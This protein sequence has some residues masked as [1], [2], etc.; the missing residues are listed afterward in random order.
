M[1]HTGRRAAWWIRFGIVGGLILAVVTS[2][3]GASWA[4]SAEIRS[5]LDEPPAAP[6]ATGPAS[7]ELREGLAVSVAGRQRRAAIG[8][9][10][11][12]ARVAAGTWTMPRAG[13]GV[14]F[15]GGR[16]G[17]WEAVKAGTDGWFSGPVLRGGYVASTVSS[18]D[19]AVM[20]L[21]ASGHAM[22]YVEREPR[23]GD[24]YA[25]GFVQLP[26]RLRKGPNVFLFQTGQGRLKAR[27]TVPKAPAFFS[28]ADT[29]T[30]D[31]IADEPASG[32]AAVMVVN[33]SETWRDDLAIAARLAGGPE[34]RTAVPSLVPL[35]VRKVGFGFRGPAQRGEGTCALALALQRKR[36]GGDGDRWET[37]DRASVML[38][39]RRP[40]QT[41]KR[42]F[43]STIDGSV[44]YYAVVP[45]LPG[46]GGPADGRPGLVLTLHGAAVEALGQAAAY[47]PKP[48]LHIVAPTNRRPYG[49]DWEDWGRLDAIEVLELAQKVLDTDPRR[50]YLTGHSMGGHGTW[51][52][53]VTF[54]DRF[55]AIAPSAGWISMWSYAGARRAES[56]SLVDQ[57]MARAGAPSDTLALVR[58]LAPIGVYILH[59]DADDNVPVGQARRMRQVMG[60][61]HPDFAYHEQTGAGHWWG[62]ACVDWPPLFAFLERRMIPAPAE[63]R[64][65]DFVTASPGVSPRAHWVTIEAQVKSMVPSTVHLELDREHRRFRGTTEN[66]ARLAID[67]GRALAEPQAGGGPIAVELDGQ[68]L[69]GLSG[70]STPPGS[71]RWIWLVRSGGTWTAAR[72][73]A[74]LARKG[75]HR[76][77][78]FKEVFRNRFV[79]VIGTKGTPEENAWGLARARFDAET[80]W[81]RGNGSVDILTDAVFLDPGRA[82]ALRDRNVILYGHSE[83]N[84]A[85]PVL[86]GD[87]PVQVRR[88]EVR[89]GG[90]VV[91]GDDLTC[92]FVRP[93]PDSERAAVGVVAGSGLIGLRLADGLP[94]F[95]SGV[96]YPDCLLL[97]GKKSSQGISV[98]IAAGYFGADWDVESGEFAWS[99]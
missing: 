11:I 63:V 23:A 30:P 80:F 69:A 34:I 85:W 58:N 81:Y 88:G 66:V 13:D 28:V 43:R 61:F 51:H 93:R 21:E 60:E 20:V 24:T 48:G 19:A 37:L 79:L 36:P 27:L 1:I 54:P 33:A 32:E 17:R 70:V 64:R 45:A 55:A 86:V 57:L 46:P 42:T 4:L 73:A 82:D 50:T 40:G 2:W 44:Q 9:D 62:N 96:A 77:G 76:Q 68:A 92:L 10:P 15:P 84:A 94:Y 18:A 31:L 35:S 71:D 97:G 89:I 6:A 49:F 87:G 12:A 7:I 14:T 53:G 29:T 95:T 38:R 99:D 41:H 74:P 78:P 16:T 91:T 25:S 72:S 67:V 3:A 26:V 83:S 98:P 52:L 65:V 5:E 39:V 59:G 22:V 8:T 75:P 56:P 90:R 47:A